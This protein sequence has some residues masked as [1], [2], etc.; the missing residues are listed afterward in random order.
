MSEGEIS[1]E[2]TAAAERPEPLP[3][4]PDPRLVAY[5]PDGGPLGWR[6]KTLFAALLLGIVLALA[7]ALWKSWT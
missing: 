1:S 3:T 4:E 7:F 2:Q 6:D 5:L